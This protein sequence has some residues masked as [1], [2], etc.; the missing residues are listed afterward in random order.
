MCAAGFSDSP[1]LMYSGRDSSGEWF[2]YYG[3]GFGGI[4]GRPFGDG[5]DGHSLWPS[6]T[7]VPNEFMEVR[8]S[9]LTFRSEV[10]RKCSS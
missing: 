4:P 2:Q 3:I 1:H 9:G 5:A 10:Q 7:N 8:A 6:F